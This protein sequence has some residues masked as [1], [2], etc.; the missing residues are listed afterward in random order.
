MRK[1]VYI[2][3]ASK[4]DRLLLRDFVEVLKASGFFI[5]APGLGFHG[6]EETPEIRGRIMAVCSYA[7]LHS[8]VFVAFYEGVGSEG[9]WDE[10]QMAQV[11]RIPRAVFVSGPWKFDAKDNTVFRMT[12]DLIGWLDELQKDTSDTKG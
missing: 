12:V 4:G 5:F 2:A 7:I 10:Y 11:Y 9:T 3:S 1:L 6:L 8:G